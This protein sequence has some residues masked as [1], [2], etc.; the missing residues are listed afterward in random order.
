MSGSCRSPSSSRNVPP[1]GTWA[2]AGAAIARSK[3]RQRRTYRL[4]MTVTKLSTSPDPPRA[5]KRRIVRA[6]NERVLYSEVDMAEI[7]LTRS[8]PFRTHR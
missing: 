4:F 1:G 7:N 2:F 3:E 5:A 6:N 8:T